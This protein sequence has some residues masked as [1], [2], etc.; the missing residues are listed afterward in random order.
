M[1]FLSLRNY[2]T[3]VRPVLTVCL[4][5]LQT[6]S[7]FHFVSQRMKVFYYIL[8]SSFLKRILVIYFLGHAF[9]SSIPIIH[10]SLLSCW[11]SRLLEQNLNFSPRRSEVTIFIF[12]ETAGSLVNNLPLPFVLQIIFLFSSWRMCMFFE[13]FINRWSSCLRIQEFYF[14]NSN[15]HIFYYFSYFS[16]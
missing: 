3:S 13:S 16:I 15:L 5:F 8:F 14:F 10:C 4:L 9:Y 7:F 6:P 1:L 2:Y 12:F 11:Y